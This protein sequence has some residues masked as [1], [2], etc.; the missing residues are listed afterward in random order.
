MLEK[1]EGAGGE[2]SLETVIQSKTGC[3]S[4]CLLL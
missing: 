1:D 4:V 3:L 2:V